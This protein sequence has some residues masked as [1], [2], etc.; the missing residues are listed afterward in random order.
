MKKTFA[1]FPLLLISILILAACGGGTTEPAAE[2]VVEQVQ[3]AAEEAAAVVEAEPVEETVA[4]DD[5]MEEEP[6]AAEEP[7]EEET[8]AEEPATESTETATVEE[9]MEE[10]PV[11]DGIAGR[12]VTG[13]DAATGLEINPLDVVAGVDYIVIGSLISFNLTP[14]DSPEFMVQSPDGTRYRVQSQAVSEI[15][16]EDGSQLLP[17]EYQRGMFATATVR[18]DDSGGVTSVVLSDDFMLLSSE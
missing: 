14:Q 11:E 2:P 1:M 13:F 17:H 6:E 18:L 3:E 5:A 4:E 16:A 15:F 8:A 7:M 10:A 12:S 9:P